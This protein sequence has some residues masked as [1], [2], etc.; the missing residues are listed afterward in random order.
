MSDTMAKHFCW[1]TS[2]TPASAPTFV[3]THRLNNNHT[4]AKSY[5]AY[6]LGRLP[7]HMTLAT[8]V[9][10]WS[11]S[12]LATINVSPPLPHEGHRCATMQLPCVHATMPCKSRHT[13]IIVAPTP[14][15]N[16]L[17]TSAPSCRPQTS[18][19]PLRCHLRPRCPRA[20]KGVVV[21]SPLCG[22]VVA[23]VRPPCHHPLLPTRSLHTVVV[24]APRVTSSPLPPCATRAVVTYAALVPSLRHSCRARLTHDRS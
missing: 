6:D 9:Y 2:P 24:H 14:L 23:H 20:T 22:S 13:I 1:P 15:H 16:T 7:P 21:T 4:D 5:Y 3:D 10:G 12:F 8:R 17:A 19:V 11:S 18:S